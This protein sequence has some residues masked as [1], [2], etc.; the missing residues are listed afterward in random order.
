M[1]THEECV[2]SSNEPRTPFLV[3]HVIKPY[4]TLKYKN[5]VH[6]LHLSD[7]T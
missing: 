2:L 7:P 5:N 1:V 3:M 6:K 4:I